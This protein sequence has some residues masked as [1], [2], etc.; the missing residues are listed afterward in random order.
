MIQVECSN[1][2]AVTIINNSYFRVTDVSTGEVATTLRPLISIKSQQTEKI[3]NFMPNVVDNTYSDRYTKSLFY[4]TSNP[5]LDIPS[6]GFLFVGTTD[7]PFGF[8]DVTVYQ[9][10]TNS[11]LDPSGLTTILYTGL[12]NLISS[13]DT[14]QYKQYTTNDLDTDSVY[15]TL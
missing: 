12:L 5:I 4:T 13:T 6:A 9:N 7:Y 11:N 2:P 14:T 15:I 1:D 10:S 3:L 8:Y